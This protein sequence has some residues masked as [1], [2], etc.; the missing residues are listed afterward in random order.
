MRV[1]KLRHCER[2]PELPGTGIC[3]AVINI[4]GRKSTQPLR[5]DQVKYRRSDTLEDENGHLL[6]AGR[7]SNFGWEHF[8]IR[9][10]VRGKDDLAGCLINIVCSDRN[11]PLRTAVCRQR[12][13]TRE[14]I[15]PLIVG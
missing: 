13:H 5:V 2:I 4:D 8:T 15:H 7:H 3:I 10:L 12:G 11:L 6:N 1:H 14:L 9:P